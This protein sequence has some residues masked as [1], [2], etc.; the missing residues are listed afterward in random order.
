MCNYL[1]IN[2]KEFTFVNLKVLYNKAFNI[3]KSYLGVDLLKF[4]ELL[5]RGFLYPVFKR[6]FT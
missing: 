6:M 1:Q 5:V 4:L 3:N 2:K